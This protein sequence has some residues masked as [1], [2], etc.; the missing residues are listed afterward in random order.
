MPAHINPA[1]RKEKSHEN[2]EYR[3][4]GNGKNAYH[5]NKCISGI[6]TG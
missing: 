3:P 6:Y 1:A 5:V 2:I 4:S